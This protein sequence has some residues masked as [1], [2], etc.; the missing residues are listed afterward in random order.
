MRANY[1][2]PLRKWLKHQPIEQIV[3]F[4]D[5]P[6]FQGATTYPCIFIAGKENADKA[7][8]ITNVK[9]LDFN[10]LAEYV[11]QNKITASQ[12]SLEDGGWNLGSETEQL[13]LRKLQSAGMPLGEY[14]K[15]KVYYGIKTGLNEAFVIDIEIKKRLIKEDKKSAEI[16]RPFLGGKDIK[17]YQALDSERFL[18]LF[19]K[20]FTNKK[21]SNPKNGWK[22]LEENYSAIANHLKPFEEKGKKRT[23]MG[24]YWWE[25]RACDYYQQFEEPKLMIPDIALRMQATYD[26]NKFYCVNT[27]YIIPKDDKYL[28]AI[29]NSN[30]IQ[31]LYLN[32]SS[33][34]RGGYLRF[35]RQ[36]LEVLPIKKIDFANKSEKSLHDEIVLLVDTMLQLQQQKQSSTLPSQLQQLEQR[37]AYT[38]D[39]INEKVYVLYGL[40]AEE[41]GVV[42]GK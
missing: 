14:V 40:S 16:I 41:I 3:D 4:G 17:R 25:L 18:I 31:F 27:A 12:N 35:I 21:G 38:D 34:I 28:L 7:I 39:T 8:E 10:S 2:E 24:D 37:I 30:L 9:K 20:G 26:I 42:E 6:V 33:A 29:L 13:L 5:L 11:Q 22:W 36:Y 1:G 19:P 23:D 15:R 32:I